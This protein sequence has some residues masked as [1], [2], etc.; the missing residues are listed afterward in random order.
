MSDGCI[1]LWEIR[2]VPEFDFGL[3]N[4]RSVVSLRPLSPLRLFLDSE[5]VSVE[6][7]ET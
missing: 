5:D 6:E 4:L 3:A 7:L 1:D 2:D